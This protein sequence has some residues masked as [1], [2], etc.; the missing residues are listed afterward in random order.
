[1]NGWWGV[2]S[3]GGN[4]EKWVLSINQQMCHGSWWQTPTH[5]LHSQT[6]CFGFTELQWKPNCLLLN[7]WS[8]KRGW[9]YEIK[10]NKNQLLCCCGRW[11]DITCSFLNISEIMGM[12]FQWLERQRDDCL[13]ALTVESVHLF[14]QR[15]NEARAEAIVIVRPNIYL[16]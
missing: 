6:V 10:P 15:V 16:S 13:N 4:A 11:R 5:L 8:N 12:E 2:A 14:C 9:N 7:Q 3:G 1:M